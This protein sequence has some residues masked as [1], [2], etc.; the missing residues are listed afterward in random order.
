M[1]DKERLCPNAAE[2]LQII[3]DLCVDYDGFN[4]ID[5][6]KSLLDDIRKITEEATRMVK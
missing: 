1:T 3:R 4:T 5:G 2:A 6:L